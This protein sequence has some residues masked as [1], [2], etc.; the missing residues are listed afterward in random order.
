M[1]KLFKNLSELIDV[2]PALV[3][4]EAWN[5]PLP[6]ETVTTT[7]RCIRAFRQTVHLSDCRVPLEVGLS[8]F[9]W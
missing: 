9:F 2:Y 4:Q 8:L 5:R 6:H 1:R 3:S 7:L